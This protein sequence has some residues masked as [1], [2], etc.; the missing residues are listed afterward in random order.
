MDDT[1]KISEKLDEVKDAI[2]NIEIPDVSNL[3]LI[4]NESLTNQV[5]RL[6]KR[7]ED[8][9]NSLRNIAHELRESN[10]VS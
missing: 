5:S 4:I 7:L 1:E 8:I 10:K 2:E 3:G 9:G 6:D